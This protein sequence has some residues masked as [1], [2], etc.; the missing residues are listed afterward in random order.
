MGK[1]G[2]SKYVND[3][4]DPTYDQA[5]GNIRKESRERLAWLQKQVQQ[6]A[7]EAGYSLEALIVK[8]KQTGAISKIG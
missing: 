5:L 3:H 1:A 4:K 7:K 2:M 8:D 6:K